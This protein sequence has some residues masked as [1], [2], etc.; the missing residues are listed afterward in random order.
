MFIEVTRFLPRDDASQ[1]AQPELSNPRMPQLRPC[2]VAMSRLQRPQHQEL[3]TPQVT[4]SLL[5]GPQHQFY[6]CTIDLSQDLPLSNISHHDTPAIGP[7]VYNSA[8]SS[9]AIALSTALAPQTILPTSKPLA[10]R[11]VYQFPN[12]KLLHRGFLLFYVAILDPS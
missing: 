6:M 3:R 4:M 12:L 11:L 10:S 5:Q 7:L 2:H 1:H 8:L 9:L